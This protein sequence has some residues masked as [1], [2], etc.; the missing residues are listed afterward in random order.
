MNI[1]Y[2]HCLRGKC[3]RALHAHESRTRGYGPRCWS[4]LLRAIR[5]LEESGKGVAGKAAQVLRDRAL[6]PMAHTARTGV[7]ACAAATIPGRV[8]HLTVDHCSC[9]AGQRRIPI[10]CNHRVALQILVA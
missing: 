3:G 10:L 5:I 2:A 6:V 7:W 4:R 9:A 8:Y 1:E